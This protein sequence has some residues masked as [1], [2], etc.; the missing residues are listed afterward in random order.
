MIWHFSGVTADANAPK[1]LLKDFNPV[2]DEALTRW[3]KY[4]LNLRDCE[5]LHA[6]AP[7]LL[8]DFKLNFWFDGTVVELHDDDEKLHDDDAIIATLRSNGSVKKCNMKC[9]LWHLSTHEENMSKRSQLE[10]GHVTFLSVNK[11]AKVSAVSVGTS[12]KPST[13]HDPSSYLEESSAIPMEVELA[14]LRR[15]VDSSLPGGM[16]VVFQAGLAEIN[17]RP[18]VERRD[19]LTVVTPSIGFSTLSMSLGTGSTIRAGSDIQLHS[20]TGK[21][22]QVGSMKTSSSTSLTD[23]MAET[24]KSLGFV[25]ADNKNI[26]TYIVLSYTAYP[27]QQDKKKLKKLSIRSIVP[28]SSDASEQLCNKAKDYLMCFQHCRGVWKCGSGGTEVKIICGAHKTIDWAND[29]FSFRDRNLNF[30]ESFPKTG[31]I[32]MHL[33]GENGDGYLGHIIEMHETI[34]HNSFDLDRSPLKSLW[35]MFINYAKTT[36]GIMLG[37]DLSIE[38][39]S[40]RNG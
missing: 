28:S 21:T 10:E 20:S 4:P 2:L 9:L 3:K 30:S 29:M 40:L 24:I 12:D 39:R 15:L 16:N 17:R 14:Y 23:S 27:E 1:P 19:L 35:D 13:N 8:Y 7:I 31:I 32:K 25:T 6:G 11:K 33:E 18:V 37:I 26:P 22:F 34:H 38:L 5:Q 36:D